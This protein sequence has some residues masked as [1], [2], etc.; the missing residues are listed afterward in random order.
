MYLSLITSKR[1]VH[2]VPFLTNVSALEPH[3]FGIFTVIPINMH[4]LT[5]SQS[6]SWSVSL[7]AGEEIE[8]TFSY[9]DGSGHRKTVKVKLDEV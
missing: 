7:S 6:K 1:Y 4:T 5:Y 3:F 2:N 9:W 8:I